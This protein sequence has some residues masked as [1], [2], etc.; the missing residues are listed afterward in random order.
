MYVT[1][2]QVGEDTSEAVPTFQYLGDM[3]GESG[4]CV[5]ATCACMG[6]F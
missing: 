2:V 1:Q 5:D 6:K 4:G 3:I